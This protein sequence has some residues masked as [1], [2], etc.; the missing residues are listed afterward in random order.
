MTS[1][2]HP[3]EVSLVLIRPIPGGR[4]RSQPLLLSRK[5]NNQKPGLLRRD[6]ALSVPNFPFLCSSR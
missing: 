6:P 4:Q 3:Q 2:P 1:S 5:V